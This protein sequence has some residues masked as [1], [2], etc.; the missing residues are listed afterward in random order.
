IAQ[1]AI[2][3]MKERPSEVLNNLCHNIPEDITAKMVA[4]AAIQKDTI[5][6]EV[7]QQ[8]IRYLGLSIAG[9]I[10]TFNPQAIFIG[11]G[12]AQNGE[13]F[14]NPL[15]EI[16]QENVFDRIS[17]KYQLLPVTFLDRAA[18]YGA[19]GLVIKEILNMDI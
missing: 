18:M 16:I 8:S 12:V 17:T 1:R 2:L 9:L 13:I 11:G 14:W 6:L 15:K 4:E 5:A 3:K 7:F 19:I 10:N